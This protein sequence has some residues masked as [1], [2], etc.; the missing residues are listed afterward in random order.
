MFRLY[1]R[2]RRRVRQRRRAAPGRRDYLARRDAARALAI[3]R[4]EHFR[5]RYE[6]VDP[7]LG[8]SL[9]HVRLAIRNQRG[10][11]GSCSARKNINFNYRILDLPAELRDYVVV[12]EMC[13]LKELH[14]G[15]AFWSLMELVIPHARALDAVARKTPIH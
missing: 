11:W 14:H 7:A 9:Q 15:P 12:H 2:I 1:F 3:G 4:I 6:L 8:T 5:R 10:R 13:H